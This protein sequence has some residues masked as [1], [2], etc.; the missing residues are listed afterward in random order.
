MLSKA[1]IQLVKDIVE[2]MGTTI[3]DFLQ[4]L[5]WF[6]F[7]IEEQFHD[8]DTG[9]YIVDFNQIY[10]VIYSWAIVILIAL[11]IK[12][13]IQTYF[14]WKTGDDDQ[15]PTRVIIGLMEA[16]IISISFGWLYTYVI[17]LGYSFWKN[18]S[19]TINAN[20]TLSAAR[21]SEIAGTSIFDSIMV[22]IAIALCVGVIWN[23]IKR[24]LQILIMRLII[25]F[26]TLGL[27]SSNGGAF[28]TIIKKFIQNFFAVII[29]LAL[30]TFA[31][32]LISADRLIYAIAVL[33][34]CINGPEMLQDFIAGAGGLGLMAL[35]SKAIQTTNQGRQLAK[36]VS[37]GVGDSVRGVANVVTAAKTAAY[38]SK[39]NSFDNNPLTFGGAKGSKYN[40]NKGGSA[41]KAA[42]RG[43]L[44]TMASGILPGR[45]NTTGSQ[46]SRI[47][48]V[49]ARGG[50]S[51]V[52]NLPSNQEDRTQQNNIAKQSSNSEKT[53]KIAKTK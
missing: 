5:Y 16:I 1:L 38:A 17:R 22:I 6:V 14:L 47:G 33:T 3:S 34:M 52:S 31:V 36:G 48:Q 10:K 39:T 2:S 20:N 32:Q 53:N 50:L 4:D 29:Q 7:Y 45:S 12:K 27:L 18:I 25:P 30:F 23:M 40:S 21:L 24:G 41:T 26:T 28:G 43:A 19:D 9:K 8:L 37:G 35:G 15:S 42:V 49:A 11:F 46:V 51:N 44:T 13:M